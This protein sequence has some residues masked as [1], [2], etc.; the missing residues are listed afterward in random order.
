MQTLDIFIAIGNTSVLL[1][2][3]SGPVCLL[4]A[5]NRIYKAFVSVSESIVIVRLKPH[6]WSRRKNNGFRFYVLSAEAAFLEN[7]CFLTDV[8]C[9]FIP[10]TGGDELSDSKGVL[11]SHL[12][13]FCFNRRGV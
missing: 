1:G 5:Y 4:S 6:A 13:N 9:L 10:N 3:E 11:G 7:D 2:A 8:L 12:Y